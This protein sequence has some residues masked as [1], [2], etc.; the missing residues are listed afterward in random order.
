MTRIV[1]AVK[2]FY[3]LLKRMFFF[4]YSTINDYFAISINFLFF[5]LGNRWNI[6]QILF[7]I[8]IFDKCEHTNSHLS[9]IFSF[10]SVRRSSFALVR[11]TSTESL[12]WV[13]QK[14]R[15]LYNKKLY[16]K[17]MLSSLIV[18]H[19]YKHNTLKRYIEKQIVHRP[20]A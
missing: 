11:N 7:Y 5:S 15:G 19:V 10:L 14:D 16:F 20:I 8:F 6:W 18:S 9:N 17:K 1:F 12:L 13:Q 4:D 3:F 2:R